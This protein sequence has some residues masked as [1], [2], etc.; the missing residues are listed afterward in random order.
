MFVFVLAEL[1]PKSWK[2]PNIQL[3]SCLNLERQM[4]HYCIELA[5][6]LENERVQQTVDP[7]MFNVTIPYI[8]RPNCWLLFWNGCKKKPPK[9]HFINPSFSENFALSNVDKE[10]PTVPKDQWVSQDIPLSNKD[11]LRITGVT[12]RNQ[13]K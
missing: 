9:D 12:R 11:Y 6:M 4:K 10:P 3:A 13:T 7:K 5:G 2:I 8:G 1:V